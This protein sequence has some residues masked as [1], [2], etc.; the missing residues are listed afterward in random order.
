MPWGG[1]GLVLAA[2]MLFMK[3]TPRRHEV[4]AQ[5]KQAQAQAAAVERPSVKEML[6]ILVAAFKALSGVVDDCSRR[7]RFPLC[8]WCSDF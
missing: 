7:R 6:A 5:K 3:E 2:I 8:A 1:L 4:E